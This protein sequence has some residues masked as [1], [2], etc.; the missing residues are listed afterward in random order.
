MVR[1]GADVVVLLAL[2]AGEF[3][4]EGFEPWSRKRE[5]LKS[6]RVEGMDG[7]LALEGFEFWA[8]STSTPVSSLVPSHIYFHLLVQMTKAMKFRVHACKFICILI[9]IY[10]VVAS[11]SIAICASCLPICASR[12]GPVLKNEYLLTRQC[13][14]CERISLGNHKQACDSEDVL[15]CVL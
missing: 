2:V 8:S 3:A 13:L 4:L 15:R 7:Y 1:L 5:H 14:Y 10:M 12:L 11:L 9:Y 6:M